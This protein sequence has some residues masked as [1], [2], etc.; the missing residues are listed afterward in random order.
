LNA[1][2]NAVSEPYPTASAEGLIGQLFRVIGKF[3]PPPAGLR[4]PSEWGNDARICELFGEASSRIESTRKNFVFRYRSADHW[5]DI[6]RRYY[7][8][9]NKA[10]EALDETRRD[11]LAAEILDLLHRFDRGRGALCVP[12]EYLEVVVDLA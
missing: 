5:L 3:L 10:F 7:G 6:F 12:A 1:R 8:P 2:L 4:S 11:E 9:V